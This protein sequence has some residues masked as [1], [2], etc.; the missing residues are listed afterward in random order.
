MSICSKI[1]LQIAAKLKKRLWKVESA[2]EISLHTMIIGIET[3]R[4]KVDKRQ[5]IGVV[6]TL[7]SDF[8]SYYS[9]VEFR[10]QDD[11][12]LTD[13]K[14]II[15]KVIQAYNKNNKVFPENII[16]YREGV[17]EAQIEKCMQIEIE[18]IK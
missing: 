15:E 2:S 13:L 9:H 11:R 7:N 5:V 18:A 4:K 16:I 3:S 1:A 6:A 8:T 12:I 17:G 10:N 14:G